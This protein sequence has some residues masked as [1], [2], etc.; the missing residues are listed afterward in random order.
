MA[1][2][3]V[4]SGVSPERHDAITLRDEVG[5]DCGEA[6]PIIRDPNEKILEYGFGASPSAGV[7]GKTLSFRPFDVLIERREN[8]GHVAAL[9]RIVE[10]SDD[11]DGRSHCR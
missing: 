7:I 8:A 5:G 6:I 4:G 9:E 10:M 2:L 11:I 1:G 3:F